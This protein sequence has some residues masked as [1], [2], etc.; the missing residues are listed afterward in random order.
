MAVSIDWGPLHGCPHN[1][2]PTVVGSVLGPH[3]QYTR[4]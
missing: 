4:T 3:I 1:K 2:N